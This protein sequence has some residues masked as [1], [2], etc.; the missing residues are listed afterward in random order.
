LYI[1][2]NTG[3]TMEYIF[4]NKQ[5]T[6]QLI[7]KAGEEKNQRY[8]NE[9]DNDSNLYSIAWNRGNNQ[10]VTI[11][12]IEYEFGANCILPIMMSQSFRFQNPADI[13]LWQFNR[14]FYCIANHDAEVG[15]VGFVFYGPSTTMF[16][17]LGEDG[18]AMINRVLAVFEEEF[19]SDEDIKA[20]MLRTLL[21]R[22]I[23]QVTRLAK[24]QY[25]GTEAAY[26]DKFNLIRQ[27][28][29]QVEIHYRKEHQVQFYAG[30]LNK[31]PK[32][33][34]NIF[35]LYSKKTPTQVIQERII[36]EAKRLFYYTDKSVKEIADDL[37]FDEVAHFSKFFKNC[38]A[39]NPS[40]LKKVAKLNK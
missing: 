7:L 9:T 37:G 20:E 38:T 6:G 21:V 40:E 10:I 2:S 1:G 8:F 19:L 25:L 33:V 29:L 35:S 30:L 18:T 31:S 5:D 13:V 22:L 28:N 27:F 23:I 12:E 32:T 16:V 39:Q 36:A 17:K 24:K 11:D 3:K 34:S 4:R 14:E 26:D 15:C